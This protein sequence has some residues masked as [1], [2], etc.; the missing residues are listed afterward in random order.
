MNAP[1]VLI[2]G[3]GG[4]LGQAWT[5]LLSAKGIAHTALTRAQL[6]LAD[7][8]AIR[9]AVTPGLRWVINCGAYTQV[10]KAEQEEALATTINGHAVGWLAAAVLDVGARLVHYSTDY[11]FSGLGTVPYPV[12]SG[13]N[14]CN[15][16]GRGKAEGERL[17]RI[18][19]VSGLLLRTSWVYAPWGTNFVRTI[20]RLLK[21]KPELKVVSD[22]RGR[23]SSALALAANTWRLCNELQLAAGEQFVGHLTDGGE[24]TWYEFAEEIGRQLHL[25]ARV[26]PCSTSE[27]PRPAKRPS[28]SVLD[29]SGT[30]KI[31]GPLP[32]W[33]LSLA[34]VL[35]R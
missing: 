31:L 13:I 33:R 12:S 8:D 26:L 32:D 18:S 34:E 5:E 4:M 27:F 1:V 20:A 28:Y 35:Q 11:V 14:P 16:Y 21:E 10:D 25:T 7:A 23:P 19:G 15:A 22:Q 30:E 2:V 3:A 6:D 9:R 17:F 24:C 29:I